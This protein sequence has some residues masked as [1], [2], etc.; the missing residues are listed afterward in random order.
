MK[1]ALKKKPMK[2]MKKKL[3]TVKAK[4]IARKARSKI[5]TKAEVLAGKKEKT[6]NGLKK[7][8]LMRS[9]AKGKIVSKRKSAVS[10]DAF[11]KNISG[12]VAACKKARQE[13]GLTGFVAIK[14]GSPVYNKAKELM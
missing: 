2:V 3:M 7:A 8:D 9:A 13:L 11:N 6:K 14:K 1:K 4:A 5:G 12:W 10:R